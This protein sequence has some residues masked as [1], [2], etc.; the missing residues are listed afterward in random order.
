MNVVIHTKLD[1]RGRLSLLPALHFPQAK[2]PTYLY[3]EVLALIIGTLV[4]VNWTLLVRQDIQPSNPFSAY[5][6]TL[7]KP[8]EPAHSAVANGFNCSDVKLDDRQYCTV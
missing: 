2:L 1:A 4:L 8:T 3:V 7:T 5:T 6:D